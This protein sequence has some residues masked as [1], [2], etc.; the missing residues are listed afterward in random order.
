M[1]GNSFGKLF[2]IT[3]F[4]ESHGAAIGVVVDGCPAGMPLSE[5]DLQAELDL[6]KPGQSAVSSPR[7]E[8]DRAEILSGVFE[9]K[10]LGTPIAILVRNEGAK[11]GDYE[12]I[13][14]VFRP[15][16][17][18]FGFFSKFGLRDFRGGGRSSGRETIA[19]VAAGAIAKKLLSRAGVKI[20]GRVV[21][22][23][24]VKEKPLE[25]SDKNYSQTVAAVRSSIVRCAD[26]IAGKKMVSEIEKARAVGDSTGGVVEVAAIGVP[27]GLGE[28]VF[29]K[30]DAEIA[31]SLMGIGSVKGVEI[32]AGFSASRMRGSENNDSFFAKNGKIATKTN[33]HGGILG[34]ISSGM[35]IVAR[36]AVKPT[37]SI[38]K[39][40]NT[41]GEG[42]EEAEI[43]VLGRHDPN[44][45]P[46]IVPVAEAMLALVLVDAMMLQ[47]KIPRSLV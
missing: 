16:H 10:T 17:A 20:I 39:T 22:A 13:K 9:G 32:G 14:R 43:S 45:C 36:I 4:G 26:Q 34:G 3:S 38:A 28:P 42:L 27:A 23:A 19:R 8:G 41:V 18:D 5:A 24:G 47:G 1:P 40:Q 2:S 46:R 44:I 29:G 7:R 11:S 12:K 30:L 35:P 37:S 31:C 21:E 25:I 15:G 33:N 6:R